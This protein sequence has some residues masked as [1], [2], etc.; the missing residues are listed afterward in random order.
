LHGFSF[1]LFALTQFSVLT[2]YPAPI[3]IL[4]FLVFLGCLWL[5][6]AAPI[7]LW[8]QDANQTTILVMALLFVEF[9]VLMRW[10]GSAVYRERRIFQTYGL[11]WNLPSLRDFLR[12]LGWG[13]ISLIL[14]FLLQISLGWLRWQTPSPAFLQI[15]LEGLASAVGTGLAEELVFRGWIL[16][17]LER[18]YSAPVALWANSLTFAILHFIKPLPEVIRTFPQ[19]PGLVLLGL[20][21]VWMKRSTRLQ[22][23][24]S[25]FPDSTNA[26]GRL[27]LPIGFHAGLIWGYYL[28][29]VGK[30]TSFTDQAPAWVTGIDG[31]PLAG[32][33]GLVFLIGLACYW[34]QF[35]LARL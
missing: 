18:D 16:Q 33:V 35:K 25:A 4:A 27:G 23:Q 19:F 24:R 26:S 5:P 22:R 14:M 8:S 13:L 31:N 30:L 9:V 32:L 12:G 10:W 28:L 21:L 15:A 3:R 34:G 20:I 1:C 2:N 11:D 7:A 17:E 6:L 29:N